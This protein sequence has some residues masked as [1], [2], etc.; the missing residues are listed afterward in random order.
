MESQA[1]DNVRTPTAA[2]LEQLGGDVRLE[3]GEDSE[4]FM[5]ASSHVLRVASPVFNRLFESGMKEAQHG[6]IKV[7]VASK[8]EFITFYNLLGPWAW[9]TDKVTEA[10]VDSLLAISDYYQVEI[11]KQT[12]EDLLLTLAPTCAR[13]LQADR[14]GLNRQYQ[15]CMGH[16]ARESTKEDL[17]LLR[18]SS[19]DMLLQVALKK[20]DHVNA[21]KT[22]RM[23]I[24][25]YLKSRPTSQSQV[26]TLAGVLRTMQMLTDN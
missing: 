2:S 22:N 9:S 4:S 23:E 5:L 17:E 1:T 16:V 20:Q 26:A 6:V 24:I 14:H 18:Q 15:R 3:F 7:D 10:N 25:K 21:L 19:P 13:L 11:I 8:Q 12:S